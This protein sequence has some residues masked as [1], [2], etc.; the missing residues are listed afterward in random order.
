MDKVKCYV[1]KETR[2]HMDKVKC[3]VFNAQ[4][5]ATRLWSPASCGQPTYILFSSAPFPP[6]VLTLVL[7]ITVHVGREKVVDVRGHCLGDAATPGWR[8]QT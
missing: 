5:G 7:A 1:C 8:R 3:Y 2:C 4:D 6:I